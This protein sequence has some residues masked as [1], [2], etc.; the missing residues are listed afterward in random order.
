MAN[1]LS[2]ILSDVF[3]NIL[4]DRCNKPHTP[5]QQNRQSQQIVIIVEAVI[6]PT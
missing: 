2:D 1:G 5:K 6:N 3:S 4:S